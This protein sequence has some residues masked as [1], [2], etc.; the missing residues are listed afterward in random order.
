M[1]TVSAIL[2]K[3]SRLLLVSPPRFAHI[4]IL[5][6][7]LSVRRQTGMDIERMVAVACEAARSAGALIAQHAGGVEVANTKASEQDLVTGG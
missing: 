3:Q 6:R 2:V 4:S 7:A 5:H 1:S